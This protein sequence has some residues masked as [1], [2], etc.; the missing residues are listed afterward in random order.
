MALIVTYTLTLVLS[1]LRM[2]SEILFMSLE[3]T[4]VVASASA[5]ISHNLFETIILYIHLF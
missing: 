1:G 4:L 3:L 5:T 2:F